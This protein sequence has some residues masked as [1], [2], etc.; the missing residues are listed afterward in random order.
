MAVTME[1]AFEGSDVMCDRDRVD[2][3]MEFAQ[4]SG[5]SSGVH[6]RAALRFFARKSHD[7]TA[8]RLAQLDAHETQTPQSDNPQP[9]RRIFRESR[10]SEVLEASSQRRIHCSAGAHDRRGVLQR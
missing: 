5:L 8:E 3:K 2:D 10:A 7:H 6:C 1:E 9:H 4:E